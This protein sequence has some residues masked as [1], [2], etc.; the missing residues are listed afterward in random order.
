MRHLLGQPRV[1]PPQN[2]NP[3]APYESPR[4]LHCTPDE[5]LP[6][7]LPDGLYNLLLTTWLRD[8]LVNA[9]EI[10][11][12]EEG[13]FNFAGTVFSGLSDPHLCP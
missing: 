11:V 7:S 3:S 10:S 4:E 8:Q 5:A 9:I 1:N 12:I 6:D 2:I 13:Y